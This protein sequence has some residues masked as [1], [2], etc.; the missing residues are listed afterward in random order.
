MYPLEALETARYRVGGSAPNPAAGLRLTVR[1]IREDS[2]RME[3]GTISSLQPLDGLG[4]ITTDAGA[5]VRFGG[6]ACRGFVPR[7]GMRVRILGTKPGYGGATKATE[8][9]S[10]E[11]PAPPTPS[12]RASSV[13][14]LDALGVVVDEPLRRVLRRWDADDAFRDDLER[15]MFEV[16]PMRAEEIDC[17]AP[18]LVVIAMNGGGSAYGLYLAPRVVETVGRP[19]VYWEHE[20][21]SLHYLAAD[22]RAFFAGYLDFADGWMRDGGVV[23]RVRAALLEEGLTLD[24]PDTSGPDF[25]AGHPASWLPQPARR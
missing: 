15:L 7:V 2:R 5:Q 23:A 4:W 17:D 10:A 12:K 6:T 21:D 24:A 22:T 1:A 11:P 8:L 20:D 25:H 19:W 3:E 13:A 14:A 16:D 18:D 9:A